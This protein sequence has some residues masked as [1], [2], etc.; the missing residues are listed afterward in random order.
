ML[1]PQL[2]EIVPFFRVYR[3]KGRQELGA[4]RVLGPP[5]AL[6]VFG[7]EIRRNLIE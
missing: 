5:I 4:E 6:R 2:S 3:R 7:L 1:A